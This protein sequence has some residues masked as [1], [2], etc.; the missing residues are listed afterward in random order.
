MPFFI[1]AKHTSDAAVPT[2]TSLAR[3]LAWQRRCC[4]F[5]L[6]SDPVAVAALVR[7]CVCLGVAQRPPVRQLSR[8]VAGKSPKQAV[9]RDGDLKG[10]QRKGYKTGCRECAQ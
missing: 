2:P 3:S 6:V 8:Q 7:V 9:V 1:L 10:E 5:A 4:S